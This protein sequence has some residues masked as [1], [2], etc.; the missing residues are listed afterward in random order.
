[1]SVPFKRTE[2]SVPFSGSGTFLLITARGLRASRT[3]S[4]RPSRLDACG[5][6]GR[7]FRSLDMIVPP[8]TGLSAA[9]VGYQVSLG[10]TF[11]YQYFQSS[12]YCAP[13]LPAQGYAGRTQPCHSLDHT[14]PECCCG[15]NHSSV[16]PALYPYKPLRCLCCNETRSSCVKLCTAEENCSRGT[17]DAYRDA[18]EGRTRKDSILK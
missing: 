5:Y 16:L 13:D 18:G 2:E 17:Q 10:V 3:S 15:S 9:A 8:R 11:Q 1:M 12:S 4:F 14:S 6:V 7:T